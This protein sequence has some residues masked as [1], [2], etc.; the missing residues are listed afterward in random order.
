MFIQK[1]IQLIVITGL[2]FLLQSCNQ[3]QKV[4][5]QG[6]LPTNATF[7]SGESF[8]K[9]LLGQAGSSPVISHNQGGVGSCSFSCNA[10]TTYNSGTNSC[11]TENQGLIDSTFVDAPVKGLRFASASSSGT[12]GDNGAYSC[13]QG[14]QVSF[15]LGTSVFLGSS[16]CMGTVFVQNLITSLNSK[17]AIG[18]AQEIGVL[19]LALNNSVVKTNPAQIDLTGIP[20]NL[21]TY[22]FSISTSSTRANINA[23]LAAVKIALPARTDIPGPYSGLTYLS[24]KGAALAHLNQNGA[25]LNAVVC[26][27]LTETL[28]NGACVL[29]SIS[30]TPNF[31][32]YGACSA[33]NACDGVGTQLR[34]VA[35]CQKIVDGVDSGIVAASFCEAGAQL[36]QSCDSPTGN[37]VESVLNGSQTSSCPAGSNVKTFV[38]LACDANYTNTDNICMTAQVNYTGLL[39]TRVDVYSGSS[40][41]GS[42]S[43]PI[44]IISSHDNKYFYSLNSS[45]TSI[46]KF[47]RL[48]VLN[49]NLLDKVDTVVS[50]SSPNKMIISRDGKNLYLSSSSGILT[51]LPLNASGDIVGVGVQYSLGG[52]IRSIVVSPDGSSLYAVLSNYSLINLSRNQTDGTLSVVSTVTVTANTINDLSITEDGLSVYV[53]TANGTVNMFNRNSINGDLGSRVDYSIGSTVNRMAISSDGKNIYVVASTTATVHM[54]PRNTTNGTLGTRVGY[55]I[56]SVSASSN[57]IVSSPDG[58]NIYFLTSGQKKIFGIPRNTGDGTLSTGTVATYDLTSLGSGTLFQINM[59]SNG[60]SIYTTMSNGILSMF[61]RN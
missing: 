20:A 21:G 30:Y 31:S 60:S 54:L 10:N 25:N 2:L 3:Y 11:E 22:D 41:P 8:I 40:S 18:A 38:S 15:Y 12:T 7:N 33:T 51:M 53:L 48:S 49:G 47:N 17:I 13:V 32:D 29:K 4:A 52:I 42:S 45:D 37:I 34:T 59:P 44:S 36:S 61:P 35:S 24:V 1:T 50:A 9:K 57:Q 56:P 19:L 39:G 6:A 55:V 5:C 14:E 28:L 26:D 27:S 16:P 58:K 46:S 23:I 43:S